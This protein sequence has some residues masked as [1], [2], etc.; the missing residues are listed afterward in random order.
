MSKVCVIM[1]GLAYQY[2]LS[3]DNIIENLIEP[4]DADVY[5]NLSRKNNIRGFNEKNEFQ[6]FP[7]S[8]TEKDINIIKNKFGKHLKGL[9]LFDEDVEYMK[10]LKK[11]NDYYIEKTKNF[12]KHESCSDVAFWFEDKNTPN[13]GSV[14]EQYF[15]VKECM[16]MVIKSG[17]KYDYCM[18]TRIDMRFNEKWNIDILKKSCIVKDESAILKQNNF[19]MDCLFSGS[20]EDMKFI[21]ENFSDRIGTFRNLAKTHGSKDSTLSPESQ[22]AQFLMANKFKTPDLLNQKSDHLN[23]SDYPKIC[24]ALSYFISFKDELLKK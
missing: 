8:L 15:H 14:N 2:L 21:C 24:K 18:R 9:Q 6:R 17:I 22:I 4:L 13:L 7:N 16:D 20:F 23:T 3:I 11:S 1:S 19:T 10:R 12:K 5:L